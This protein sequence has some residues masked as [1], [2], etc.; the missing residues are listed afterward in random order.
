MGLYLWG[1]CPGTVRLPEVPE[2]TPLTYEPYEL[3]Q[4]VWVLTSR[5]KRPGVIYM[6][7]SDDRYDVKDDDGIT[8]WSNVGPDRLERRILFREFL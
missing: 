7:Y 1:V 5:G 8:H 6:V 4:R 2:G 3:D